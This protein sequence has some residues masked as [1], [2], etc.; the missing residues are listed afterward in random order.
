MRVAKLWSL[1]WKRRALMRERR[2][3]HQEARGI[4]WALAENQKDAIACERQ[5][6]ELTEVER[7][8]EWVRRFRVKI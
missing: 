2:R 3:L 8:E 1:K 6:S 7:R 4:E 5:I